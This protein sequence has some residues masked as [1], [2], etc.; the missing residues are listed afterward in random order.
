MTHFD[1]ALDAFGSAYPEQPAL[2]SHGLADHPLLQ[3]D[4]LA[5]LAGRIRPIDVEYYPGDTPFGIDPLTAPGNG[6]SVQETIRRIE[7]CGS[8]MVL[9][10]VEQDEIFR[11]FLL[12][13]LA[14]LEEAV[15]ATTGEMLKHR[16]FVFITSPGSVT[17]LHFDPEHNILLQVRGTKTMAIFPPDDEHV[18]PAQEHERFHTGGHRN[19]PWRD[20]FASRGREFDLA[21][22]QAVH[23]P[24]MAPHW[25]RNGPQVSVSFSITWRSEW[26]YRE[27]YAHRMNALLRKAGLSPARPKRY[28]HQNHVK[29]LGYRVID[30]ARRLRSQPAEK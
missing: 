28:P 20:E 21:P 9:K 26:S 13:A 12:E 19:L 15:G 5:A 6:L 14:P 24:F 10:F 2:L 18:V 11:N 8:W 16:G 23:V 29:S 27:E 7:E 17:P 22:G 3:L 30:K 25:V 4:A 1:D